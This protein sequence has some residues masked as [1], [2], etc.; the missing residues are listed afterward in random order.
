MAVYSHPMHGL[1]VPLI[2]D[3]RSYMAKFPWN[4]AAGMGDVIESLA[5]PIAKA[6]RLECLDMDDQLKP[7]S[8]CAKRRDAANRAIPFG[9]SGGKPGGRI[10]GG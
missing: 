6:F 2:M 8:D 4:R 3:W 1:R 9:G 5:K 7:E 10:T